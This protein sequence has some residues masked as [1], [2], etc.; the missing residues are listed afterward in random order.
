MA[1]AGGEEGQLCPTCCKID[2]R[3]AFSLRV[4][5]AVSDHDFLHWSQHL[6]YLKDIVS[7]HQCPFCRLS[8]AALLARWPVKPCV[9]EDLISAKTIDNDQV[10]CYAHSTEAGRRGARYHAAQI[11]ISTNI[12]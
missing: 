9:I 12:E 11:S 1:L 4:D 8:V 2:F 5:K 6:G 3:L 7:R 10:K